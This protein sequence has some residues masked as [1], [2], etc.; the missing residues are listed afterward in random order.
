MAQG[1]PTMQSS[2]ANN[3]PSSLAVDGDTDENM[4]N[5]SCSQ[6]RTS[7]TNP[8]WR[9]DL[10]SCYSITKVTVYSRRVVNM[11]IRIGRREYS[12]E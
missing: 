6:T 5:S 2:T 12:R 8:W 9:V 11:E 1:K 3:A 10:G 7:E 4:D